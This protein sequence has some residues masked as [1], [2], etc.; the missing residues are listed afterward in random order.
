M[1]MSR[2]PTRR[3]MP[4][5]V[6]KDNSLLKSTLPSRWLLPTRSRTRKLVLTVRTLAV[7][8]TETSLSVSVYLLE[9]YSGL[10]WCSGSTDESSDP[11]KW[12]FTDDYQNTCRCSMI[13][14]ILDLSPLP[15]Q[16]SMV[17][18][19]H[20]TPPPSRTNERCND[21]KLVIRTT[22]LLNLPTIRTHP[23]TRLRATGNRILPRTLDLSRRTLSM[24]W[25][26]SRTSTLRLVVGIWLGGVM[27]R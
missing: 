20:S 26:P 13:D 19:V 2:R 6:Y 3:S 11:T 25:S 14:L 24:I 7:L 27:Y 18:L 15:P 9:V 16:W 23:T 12:Q 1:P 22:W 21:N 17:D 10:V 8:G 4:K 5:P